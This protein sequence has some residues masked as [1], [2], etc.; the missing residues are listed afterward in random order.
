[1]KFRNS[2][3][4]LISMCVL[5]MFGLLM[6]NE[7]RKMHEDSV[8]ASW[9][10]DRYQTTQ[11]SLNFDGLGLVPGGEVSYKLKLTPMASVYADLIMKFNEDATAQDSPLKNYA[12][13]KI[14][15]DDELVI[16][17]LLADVFDTSFQYK[18]E[19]KKIVEDKPFYI[20]VIF[21]MPID[22]EANEVKNA[23]TK[24]DL[25]VTVENQDVD[26]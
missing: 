14:L 20:E 8:H 23:E 2:I 7:I 5:C 4:L 18:K 22:V 24:F 16:D 1:M 10:V 3:L 15:V 6:T 9:S 13:V 25:L 21:Y 11:K 19:G 17:E 12:W 26:G